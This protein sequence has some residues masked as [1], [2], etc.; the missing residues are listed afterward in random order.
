MRHRGQSLGRSILDPLDSFLIDPPVVRDW[1]ALGISPVG[2]TLMPDTIGVYHIWDWIGEGF[3]KRPADF[4]EEIRAFG[5][6]RRLPMTL[7]FAKLT[8]NSRIICIHAKAFWTNFA[9]TLSSIQWMPTD[10]KCRTGK[11]N[12]EDLSLAPHD[13]QRMHAEMCASL[14]WVDIPTDEIESGDYSNTIA[15]YLGCN[16]INRKMPAHNA[17][18]KADLTYVCG[19]RPNVTPDY[20]A[21]A[22]MS[23]PITM[24]EVINDPIA[25]THIASLKAV[26]K[27]G[28]PSQT[29]NY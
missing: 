16:P 5:L 20:S 4:V 25:Q 27:S 24:L 11:T 18:R 2:V 14:L 6:S 22:F 29:V 15:G 12:H 17:G 7:D 3:Y 26:A 8:V 19:E 10:W 28:L 1:P 21:A 9:A 13:K 23:L